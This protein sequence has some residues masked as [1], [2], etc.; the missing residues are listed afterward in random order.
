MSMR[1]DVYLYRVRHGIGGVTRRA[2]AVRGGDVIA[3]GL[4]KSGVANE[5]LCIMSYNEMKR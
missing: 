4:D 5:W 2:V 3:A 1:S